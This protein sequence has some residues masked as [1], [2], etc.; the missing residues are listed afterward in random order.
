MSRG[1][2]SL[3]TMRVA[4]QT[5]AAA[6]AFLTLF[7]AVFFYM[8]GPS[9]AVAL[10]RLIA[11]GGAVL[12]W[13]ISAAGFGWFILR[14]LGIRRPP[15][16]NLTLEIITATALGLGAMSLAILCL[17][18]LGQLNHMAAVA[19]IAV[20]AVAALFAATIEKQR[21]WMPRENRRDSSMHRWLFVL[22]APLIAITILADLYPPGV[23]WGDEPNGYDVT[24]YHLQV[25]REWYEAGKIVPLHHNVYSYLPFSVEMHYLLAMHLH[26]GDNGPWSGMYLAQLMHAA[27]WGLALAAIYALAG[28]GIRGALAATI[29]AAAPWTGLL[30]S[31]AYNEGGMVLWGTL[32]IGWAMRA[33]TFGEFALAGLFAGFSTGAKLT[34]APLLFAG[35][36]AAMIL[37]AILFRARLTIGGWIIFVL[38]AFVAFAPWAIRNQQWTGNPLFPEAMQLFGKGH[39]SPVQAE[40]WRE[41]YWPD[42]NHRS[43]TGHAAALWQ[44]VLADWRY[45]Y[46]IIP[47][48]IAAAILGRR[49]RT[50][51]FLFLLAIT[52]LFIWIGFTHLQSRFMVIVIPIIA[53]LIVQVDFPGWKIFCSAVAV[54]LIVFATAAIGLKLQSISRRAPDLAQL[55]GRENIELHPF[56]GNDPV[57]L[58]GDATAFWYRIPMTRLHYKTVFDVDTSDPHKTIVQDWLAGMPPTPDVEIDPGELDRFARTYYGIP[59][60]AGGSSD[61]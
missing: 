49:N 43:I 28:G 9:W 15:D 60:L 59:P 29:A 25:P 16:S 27:I 13:L 30:A 58:V 56:P 5:L 31:V 47:L 40:R 38:C 2:S 34:A 7:F 61:K 4:P 33:K 22:L 41:A 39:F 23:L 18:L 21:C 37:T 54:A 6:G 12:L 45:G 19:M 55:I 11:D 17:G 32:A 3:P 50:A 42:K 14:I 36:P 1:N 8:A 26:G 57:D 35:I 24:E 10:Y 52:Q 20:G 51:M 48:G 53:L 46:A 44:Q